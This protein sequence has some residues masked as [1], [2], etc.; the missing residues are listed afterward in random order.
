[1]PS[2][3]NRVVDMRFNNAQ[4]ERG[5]AQSTKTLKE[6]EKSLQLKDAGKSLTDLERSMN[7]FSLAKMADSVDMIA[8]RFTL[9]GRVGMRVLDNLVDS[10]MNAG[11]R[12]VSALTIAPLKTG[13]QEYELKM[14]AVQTLMAGTGESLERV[15]TKL[16][17][18]N[19]YSDK[20]IYSF[21][22]MT[23]NIGK[24][25]NAGVSLDESV[26]ALKGIANWAAR[27]GA[28]ANEASRAM[29][30]MGQAL[31][32]GTVLVRDWMSIENANM[33]TVEFKNQVI[34]AAEELGVLQAGHE[35]TA[36]NF[37]SMLETGF[38]TKDVLTQVL[39]MYGDETS[40]IGKKATEAATQVKTLTMLWDTLKESVQSGWA[41]SWE[42]I[43]GDFDEAKQLFT[44]LSK[45]LG[46]ALDNASNNRNEILSQWRT[47]GGREDLGY[48]FSSLILVVQN[49]SG[50]IK[51]AFKDIFG[52]LTG[53]GLKDAS[54]KLRAFFTDIY[55]W[56]SGGKDGRGTNRFEQIGQIFK[57]VFSIFDLGIQVVSG[58]AG[59]FGA[60][61]GL[62]GGPGDILGTVLDFFSGIG[63]SVSNFAEKLRKDG[64]I[65]QWFTRIGEFFAPMITKFAEWGPKIGA[66]FKGIWED[67]GKSEAWTTITTAVSNFFKGIPDTLS[68]WATAIGDFLGPVIEKFPEWRTK[69]VTFFTDLWAS[70]SQ[71]EVWGKIWNGLKG[72]IQGV[73]GFMEGVWT[74]A[75]GLWTYLTTNESIKKWIKGISDFIGPYVEKIKAFGLSI[76][77]AIKGIFGGNKDKGL[78]PKKSW[79]EVLKE[80]FAT[81]EG[82]KAYFDGLAATVKQWFSDFKTKLAD[83]WGKVTDFFSGL[84]GKKTETGAEGITQQISFIDRLKAFF[85]KIK[86]FLAN[87]WG[88]IAGG[89]VVFTFIKIYSLAKQITRVIGY[90]GQA[91]LAEESRK[92]RIGLDTVGTT[93]MKIAGSL[94][95]VAGAI[96][97]ISAI[98]Q[99]KLWVSVGVIV[100]IGILMSALALSTKKTKLP[101]N[102]GYNMMAMAG[103]VLLIVMAVKEVMALLGSVGDP[104]DLIPSATIVVGILSV[105]MLF[106]K[107]L[108]NTSITGKDGWKTILAI[109]ASVWILVKTLQ[110]L[111]KLS[112]EDLGKMG[113]ALGGLTLAIMAL[114]GI[115]K[116][117]AKGAG[118]KTKIAG[119]IG[120]AIGVALLIGALK[121]VAKM[122]KDS[123]IKMGAVFGTIAVALGLILAAS[124]G[125]SLAGTASILAALIPLIFIIEAMGEAIGKVKDVSWEQ[126]LAFTGGLA[127]M[128]AAMSAGSFLSNLNKAV[129]IK[130]MVSQ[131]LNM[132]AMGGLIWAL[133]DALSKLPNI[134][135]DKIW[136][137]TIGVAIIAAAG[138]VESLLSGIRAWGGLSAAISKGA[139]AFVINELGSAL[140]KVKA[141]SSD[142]IKSFTN[143]VALIAAAGGVGNLISGI[144]PWGGLSAAISQGALA[145]IINELGSALEKVK[146]VASDTI[147]SFTD[148]VALIAAA[149]S[150]GNLISGIFPWVG[151]VGAVANNALA[152]VIEA[153]GTALKKTEGVDTGKIRSFTE[154][155]AMLVGIKTNLG[156]LEGF[157]EALRN[158]S[159]GGV[160]EELGDA[161]SE[162]KTAGVT[163]ENITAFT[164][165]ITDI[166]TFAEN[167]EKEGVGERLQ[168]IVLGTPLQTFA[169][170]LSSF[171]TGISDLSAALSGI[172]LPVLFYLQTLVA[173]ASAKAIS[174]FIEGLKATNIEKY[175]NDD[176]PA[177]QF[178]AY[179][180][181]ADMV[182]FAGGVSAIADS[183]KKTVGLDMS[184]KT[185]EAVAAVTA[186]G[187]FLTDLGSPDSSI[188]LENISAWNR[189]WGQTDET[190]T[191]KSHLTRFAEG[192]NPVAESFKDISVGK[193]LPKMQE[194]IDATQLV[195]TFLQAIK[196]PG[197]LPKYDDMAFEEAGLFAYTFRDFLADYAQLGQT[198][199][200]FDT[201][202]K[203]LDSGKLTA[204]VTSLTGFINSISFSSEALES[205]GIGKVK[206]VLETL[207]GYL[208]EF[209]AS[210][211]QDVA[212]GIQSEETS[213]SP[214]A[215]AWQAIMDTTSTALSSFSSQFMN[216]GINF[217]IG[218][219]RGITT[220]RSAAINAAIKL[221]ADALNATKKVL[222][223]ESPSREAANIGRFFGQ[224]LAVGISKTTSAVMAASSG[225]GASILGSLRDELGIHSESDKVIDIMGWL[226]KSITSGVGRIIQPVKRSS[227]DLGS[228]II[229]SFR[230]GIGIHSENKEISN[231]NTG[232]IGWLGKS[233]TNGIEL[234]KPSVQNVAESLGITVTNGFTDG[235][236][237]GLE[238]VKSFLGGTNGAT[239]ELEDTYNSMFGPV[240]DGNVQT[241]PKTDTRTDTKTDPKSGG[242][243]TKS[244]SGI[245]SGGPVAENAVRNISGTVGKGL[246]Q[247]ENFSYL[248]DR[249]RELNENIAGMK[250][251]MDNGVLVGQILTPIDRRLGRE[252]AYQGRR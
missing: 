151:L 28:G 83:I 195:V 160:I 13:F 14:T 221:A 191:L 231:P 174:H 145:F 228:S 198:V 138:G 146:G 234:I 39:G 162:I 124:K 167:M 1:M 252:A 131:L 54:A 2:V 43:V 149:G 29:Y 46:A 197:V 246:S 50:E 222:K 114:I 186:I 95:I 248:D 239:Q 130:G 200:E 245:S 30:N 94:A 109:A 232:I 159:L 40:E 166:L 139:L 92:A 6:L 58:I 69:V 57:G 32:Q 136:A 201:N 72:F 73:P 208:K 55:Y 115:S 134:S 157:A 104:R 143:G 34:R 223:V 15:N 9:M 22:D 184:G 137:F 242:S 207:G 204:I 178:A 210:L 100:G 125:S 133:G 88:W 226:G 235:L 89:L 12:I 171:S 65:K 241:D 7:A 237:S 105:L 24:F 155:V 53:E 71:S 224:G 84:F 20:T 135:A 66:F 80:K 82:I 158:A 215:N 70:V 187:Q 38:F 154:G 244:G 189:F 218:L 173:I 156:L 56:M 10:A 78:A 185:A 19:E 75:K 79:I 233:I 177:A 86:E 47:L 164:T 93:L 99:E 214:I 5:V 211:P 103:S 60:L 163:N 249:L 236:K 247:L 97:M 217:A 16:N 52:S 85:G 238:K 148:G 127:I 132:V 48:A 170:E 35:V 227:A 176:N 81:P 128:I 67:L 152:N 196:A 44:G 59:A 111:T 188:K 106:A 180:L 68:N 240:V 27:S 102:T 123:L 17:E 181:E 25:T 183:L 4:F 190:D 153:L 122:N 108:N 129:S 225:L 199:K 161:L 98:P 90:F 41:Q 31:G 205:D 101:S 209:G 229:E 121:P 62:L 230:D 37:R 213:F 202:I 64:T 77:N 87:N 172:K 212:D 147:K 117:G 118:G 192:L 193:F 61:F 45:I 96:W 119:M 51:K 91:K 18:L 42:L 21:S 220:G 3:D 194:A 150:V 206:E 107:G 142:K 49:V 141:V 169:S 26:E 76:W 33:A 203:D 243:G 175:L 144:L 216:T 126:I 140:E 165:A 36:E 116:L 112:W 168:A 113:A 23:S 182:A 219:G 8:S 110:P 74:F 63:E 251:V 120:L 11:K 179:D 250:I